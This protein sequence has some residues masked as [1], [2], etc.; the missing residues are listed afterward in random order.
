MAKQP[1]AKTTSKAAKA[2]TKK[3]DFSKLT[4]QELLKKI[5][6]LRLE[7]Q[8]L[9]R[10]TKVGEVQNVKAYAAKRKELARALTTRNQVTEVK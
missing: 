5:D 10:G 6:E 7:V 1:T 9:K 4:E 2:T 3:V 8:E